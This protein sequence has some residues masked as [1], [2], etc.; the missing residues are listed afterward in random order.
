MQPRLDDTKASPGTVRA[1]FGLEVYL[2][3][4]GLWSTGS[5]TW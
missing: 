3:G 4:C 1:L 5:Y 2:P